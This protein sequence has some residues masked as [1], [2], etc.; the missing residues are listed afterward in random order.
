MLYRTHGCCTMLEA[1]CVLHR[2]A[3]V[4]LWGAWCCVTVCV[5]LCCQ[6]ERMRCV[7]LCCFVLVGGCV[8]C[9]VLEERQACCVAWCCVGEKAGVLCCIMPCGVVQRECVVLCCVVQRSCVF[10][11][12]ER[13]RRAGNP[14]PHLPLPP[15]VSGKAPG[16]KVEPRGAGAAAGCRVHGAGL[17]IEEQPGWHNPRGPLSQPGLAPQDPLGRPAPGP[18]SPEP[19]SGAVHGHPGTRLDRAAGAPGCPSPAGPHQQAPQPRP[20]GGGS[21]QSPLHG[22]GAGSSSRQCRMLSP[23]ACPPTT[24]RQ[25][26]P[27]SRL[28]GA[29]P[30]RLAR[31]P[32]AGANEARAVR[33][34]RA[35]AP[36]PP[37][38]LRSIPIILQ[39]RQRCQIFR[40]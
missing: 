25:Q 3:C 7:A 21:C 14:A 12:A 18:P 8:L 27:A 36:P 20:G 37:P 24:G 19:A 26:T 10:A 31:S 5:V 29:R 4:V 6:R 15:G 40:G 34:P 39:H 9:S 1:A 30:R 22:A 17:G 33:L 16:A 23:D 2:N 32:R 28:P 13:L 35:A 38:R 11:G